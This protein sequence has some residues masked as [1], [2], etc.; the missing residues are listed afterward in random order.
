MTIEPTAAIMPQDIVL[1]MPPS[2]INNNLDSVAYMP[3]YDMDSMVRTMN[4]LQ[5]SV[6]KDNPEE[7]I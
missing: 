7:N 6:K 4:N 5:S 3:D 1:T 2:T